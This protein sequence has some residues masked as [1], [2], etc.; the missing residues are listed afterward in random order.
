MSKDIM[1]TDADSE[2]QNPVGES[3]EADVDHEMENMF[4]NDDEDAKMGS[5][6]PE[7]LYERID[8]MHDSC[9]QDIEKSPSPQI[10][11][12]HL[13]CM[14]SIRGSFHSDI[15]S[16]GWIIRL[17]HLWILPIENS[18]SHS[19]TIHI[20]DINLTQQRTCE[21]YVGSDTTP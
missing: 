7:P 8:D 6:Q 15:F 4:A 17:H 1:I 13:S 21:F 3:Q 2:N 18:P 16:N 11:W 9:L 10:T 20:S 14:L 19:P 12:I 5:S